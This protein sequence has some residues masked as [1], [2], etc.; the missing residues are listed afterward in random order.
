MIVMELFLPLG[1]VNDHEC[2]EIERGDEANNSEDIE[3]WLLHPLLKAVFPWGN[4]NICSIKVS[5][6]TVV[7][8]L[9]S[10]EKT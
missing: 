2:T 4:L 7:P 1:I 9:S 3:S 6:K 5:R 10:E 8:S